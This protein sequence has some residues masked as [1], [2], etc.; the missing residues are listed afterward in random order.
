MEYILIPLRE[1]QVDG[2]NDQQCRDELFVGKFIVSHYDSLEQCYLKAIHGLLDFTSQF[3]FTRLHIEIPSIL[4]MVHSVVHFSRHFCWM[5]KVLAI[6]I[7]SSS[8]NANIHRIHISRDCS[9][10]CINNLSLYSWKR[11]QLSTFQSLYGNEFNQIKVKMKIETQIDE[12]HFVCKGLNC[13]LNFTLKLK[14]F[15]SLLCFLD[16]KWTNDLVWF[17]KL[18]L[19][20]K[21]IFSQLVWCLVLKGQQVE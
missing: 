13:F 16:F 9:T 18:Q 10:F 19:I 4:F 8:Y 21:K 12:L 5:N 15:F 2:S 6:E 7:F 3:N 17:G 11:A 1:F 14:L 20:W